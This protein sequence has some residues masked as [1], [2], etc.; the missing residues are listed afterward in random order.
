MGYQDENVSGNGGHSHLGALRAYR[1]VSF[2]IERCVEGNLFLDLS[3]DDP[4][5]GAALSMRTASQESRYW[6]PQSSSL[7][8]HIEVWST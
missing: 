8:T 5:Q 4:E 1:L 7:L 3:S 2:F 6:I